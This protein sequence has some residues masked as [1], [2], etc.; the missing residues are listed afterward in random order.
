YPGS[1][2]ALTLVVLVAG[3]LSSSSLPATSSS[4]SDTELEH[5]LRKG[6]IVG[7][8]L[9][10][11]GITRPHRL[12][13]ECEGLR[14]RAA[15]KT[16]DQELKGLTRFENASPE[17]HFTDSYRYECAAYLI[18][19]YLGLNMV[20]VAVTR[21]VGR[22]QGAAIAWVENAISPEELRQTPLTDAER[23]RISYQEGLKTLFDGL[24]QNVDRNQ[25]NMLITPDDL[26][27]HLIDHSR[28]FRQNKQLPAKLVNERIA[29]PEEFY[30]RLRQLSLMEDKELREITGKT[31][32]RALSRAVIVRAALIVEEIERDRAAY[33]DEAVFKTLPGSGR[34]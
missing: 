9:I 19:R 22:D 33:G 26:R 27:L 17:L 12:D 1:L 24:I 34:N 11:T 18:D 21:F 10:G 28:A 25:G 30:E 2:G 15:F 5:C 31:I 29:L 13:L 32:S 7:N 23:S 16:F 3:G 8:R 4:P 6:E 20:P 14:I